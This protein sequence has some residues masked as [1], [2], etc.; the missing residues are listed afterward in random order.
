M[1]LGAH[2][3]CLIFLPNFNKYGIPQHIF[4]EVHSTKFHLNQPRGSHADTCGWMYIRDKGQRSNAPKKYTLL[5]IMFYVNKQQHY[6]F[7]TTQ[8]E[9]ET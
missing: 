2:V 7:R 1:Y 9:D 3:R 8:E 4:R 6:N 5:F